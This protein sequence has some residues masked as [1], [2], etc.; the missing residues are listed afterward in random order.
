[1]EITLEEPS[2]SVRLFN[3]KEC[4]NLTLCELDN[5]DHTAT[6]TVL[7]LE[8][9]GQ[10]RWTCPQRVCDKT[11][12]D[13]CCTWGPGAVLPGVICVFFLSRLRT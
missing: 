10:H 8:D 6:Q 5:G 9:P 11:L 4:E 3:I 13:G 12:N 2:T 7:G 1:M